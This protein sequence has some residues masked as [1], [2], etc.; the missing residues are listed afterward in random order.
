MTKSILVSE[1]FISSENCSCRQFIKWKLVT[2][3]APHLHVYH[4]HNCLI[5]IA[6]AYFLL[7]S[8]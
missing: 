3:W 7:T 6:I 5:C 4:A 1:H 8:S 2:G